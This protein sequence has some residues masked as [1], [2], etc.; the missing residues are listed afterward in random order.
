MKNY[1]Y[2]N[3]CRRDVKA[4]LFGSNLALKLGFELSERI[5]HLAL[6][7]LLDHLGKFLSQK[8]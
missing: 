5:P 3:H 1:Y 4:S 8:A 6:S 2:L 7:A